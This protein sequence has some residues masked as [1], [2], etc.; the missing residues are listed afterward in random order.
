[1]MDAIKR[2][3]FSCDSLDKLVGIDDID[4]SWLLDA[5]EGVNLGWP[6]DPP[7]MVE[8]QQDPDLTCLSSMTIAEEEATVSPPPAETP[9]EP[10]VILSARSVPVPPADDTSVIEGLPPAGAF[11][12][13]SRPE[14]KQKEKTTKTKRCVDEAC[15]SHLTLPR[16][17]FI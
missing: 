4:T 9:A 6:L 17:F 1:M 15:P 5:E 16:A 11:T 8:G 13:T 3:K 12:A 10:N 2:E 7:V 14:R